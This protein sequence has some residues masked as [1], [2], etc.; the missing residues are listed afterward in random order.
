MKLSTLISIA[1]IVS[2]IVQGIA[3]VLPE[4][5]SHAFMDAAKTLLFGGTGIFIV[6]MIVLS[7]LGVTIGV[8]RRF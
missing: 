3:F 1:V 7:F 4:A 8:I 6:V 2:A 5:L